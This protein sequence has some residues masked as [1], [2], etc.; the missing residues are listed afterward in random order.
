MGCHTQQRWHVSYTAQ[1]DQPSGL[2]QPY[3]HNTLNSNI[4]QHTVINQHRVMKHNEMR[5]NGKAGNS[6]KHLHLHW[7]K[8]QVCYVGECTSL[9]QHAALPGDY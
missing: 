3:T 7:P 4:I 6:G 5:C 2:C 1:T 8:Q 9:L